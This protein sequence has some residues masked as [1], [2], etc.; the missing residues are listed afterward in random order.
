MTA[1]TGEVNRSSHRR[2]VTLSTVRTLP[3]RADR[4]TLVK[5]D[6]RDITAIAEQTWAPVVERNQPAHLFRYE[7]SLVAVE[8]D[9]PTELGEHDLC[10][11][12]DAAVRF[13]DGGRPKYTPVR[14]LNFMLTNVD[15]AIPELRRVRRVPTFT[16]DER[17]LLTPGFDEA[18]GTFVALPPEL[19]GLDVPSR[20][21]PRQV[22][23]AVDRFRDLLVDFPLCGP[24]DFA[25]SLAVVITPLVLPLIGDDAGQ[26]G[27]VTLANTPRTGKGLLLKTL[28]AVVTGADLPHQDWSGSNAEM[29]K[30]ITAALRDAPIYFLLDNI[31]GTLASTALEVYHTTRLWSDRELGHSRRLVLSGDTMLLYT[32][33][34]IVIGGDLP[35]RLFPICLDSGL[36]SPEER[37][38]FRYNL[39]TYAR[40]NRPKLLT[41]ALTLVTNWLA[42]GRPAFT[43][44]TFGGF[45][46]WHAVLGGIL[47]AAGVPGFLDNLDRVRR[48]DEDRAALHRLVG[49]WLTSEYAT[50]PA[51]SAALYV[52]LGH[53]EGIDLARGDERSR[54]NHLGKLLGSLRNRPIL[55]Y[56]VVETT[57]D[58]EGFRRWLL[59]PAQAETTMN[60]REREQALDLAKSWNW[61]PVRLPGGQ[62][63][64]PG[65]P[66]W[67]AWVPTASAADLGVVIQLLDDAQGN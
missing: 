33:N 45:D 54:I 50:K 63:V 38:G 31:R 18:T 51:T 30:A 42:L 49:V 59:E 43:G 53:V 65:E 6:S 46:A 32:G 24:A 21:S 67:R 20:P 3:P 29:R 23:D 9:T 47:Q 61:L 34:N 16:A 40:Q 39:P 2:G 14:L 5:L 55:G 4:R 26:P 10:A 7:R 66:S 58:R 57:T 17:L 41:G 52:V 8:G 19:I 62:V 37:S 35:F 56:R 44:P 25:A 27:C 22:A 28:T 60:G 11:V 13:T 15:R 48:Q 12:V 64:E 1:T 36:E